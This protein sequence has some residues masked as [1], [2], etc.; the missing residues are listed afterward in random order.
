MDSWSE[1]ELK[2]MEVGGNANMLEFWKSQGFPSNLAIPVRALPMRCRL[3]ICC[4]V[5]AH[6][7][8]KYNCEAMAAYRERIKA[9]AMGKSPAAIPR[10]GYKPGGG[11]SSLTSATA[12][13]TE[14]EAHSAATAR[15]SA[16][17]PRA[18][19][20]SCS[21][22]SLLL[23]SARPVQT[24]CATVHALTARAL[25]SCAATVAA[26]THNHRGGKWKRLD[27]VRDSLVAFQL[28]EFG[29]GFP[30]PIDDGG[31]RSGLG[32]GG[33]SGGDFRTDI[34]GTLSNV[35]SK[36]TDAAAG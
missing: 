21:V 31:K 11:V 1:R 14:F 17:L 35:G 2:I 33:G 23:S 12:K 29:F 30:G 32:A 34:S 36:L 6:A 19:R 15:R 7:Q 3:L 10:I 13:R 8:E 25:R 26:T 20:C 28:S 9:L 5:C 16:L 4:V 22:L 18:V 27:L 24:R